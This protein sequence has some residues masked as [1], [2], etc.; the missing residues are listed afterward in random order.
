MDKWLR[1][2]RPLEKPSNDDF[3]EEIEMKPMGRYLNKNYV[4]LKSVYELS[5]LELLEHPVTKAAI[6]RGLVYRVTPLSK[7]PATRPESFGSQEKTFESSTGIGLD[8]KQAGN[9]GRTYYN[10]GSAL[11]RQVNQYARAEVAKQQPT[12]T[13]VPT[14]STMVVPNKWN[15]PEQKCYQRNDTVACK[16]DG[17]QYFK[18]WVDQAGETKPAREIQWVKPQGY[19][20]LSVTYKIN[21]AAMED[22]ISLID[23]RVGSYGG[24]FQ[25]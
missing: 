19:S 9:R 22:S 5:E 23:R 14:T 1:C 4:T 13:G 7:K 21:S 24:E 2:I 15:Q 17:V 6:N 12:M 20:D 11:H 8:G 3:V 10:D 18:G 16:T 25:R